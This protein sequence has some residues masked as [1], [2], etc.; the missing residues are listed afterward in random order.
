MLAEHLLCADVI[1]LAGIQQRTK[2]TKDPT[3]GEIV[4]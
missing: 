4:S 3:L 1:A 2:Q